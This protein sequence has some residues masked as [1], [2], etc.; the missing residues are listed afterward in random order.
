VNTTGL[1]REWSMEGALSDL[2][3]RFAPSADLLAM[4]AEE[5]SEPTAEPAQNLLMVKPAGED[6]WRPLAGG[7]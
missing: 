1:I 4:V 7:D 5:P 6:E 3:R 2:E